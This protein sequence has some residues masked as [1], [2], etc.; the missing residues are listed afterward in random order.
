MDEQQK[1]LFIGN[2][3]LALEDPGLS[4][5]FGITNMGV[6]VEDLERSIDAEVE[7][8]QKELITVKEYEKLRNQIESEF[9]TN[10][11][12]VAG[13]AESLATYH[14]FF[15]DAN[16]I[17]TEMDRYLA[18]T[19]EDIMAAAKKYLA[20]NNRVVLYYLPKTMDSKS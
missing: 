1:A 10:N 5:S 3:P 6:T 8:L 9:V 20:K 15:G 19:R 16:L 11:S 12:R 18:V 17:N 14:M 4:L 13:I 2:F 7:K